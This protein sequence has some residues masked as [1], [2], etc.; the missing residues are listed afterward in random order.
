MSGADQ[1]MM[2]TRTLLWQG[3]ELENKCKIAEEREREWRGCKNGDDI[4]LK[5][6]ALF[7]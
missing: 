7:I 4:Y 2:N 5:Y 1:T 3:N 6:L